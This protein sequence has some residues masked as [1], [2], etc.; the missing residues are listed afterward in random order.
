MFTQS[1][2]HRMTPTL[3]VIDPR[4]LQIRTVAYYRSVAELP[5]QAGIT[6]QVFD[7][8]TRL[9]RSW[10]A[11]LASISATPNL[12][13]TFS[14]SDKPLLADSVDTGWRVVLYGSTGVPLC[15]WDGR[16]SQRQIAYDTALRPVAITEQTQDAQPCVSERLTYAEISNEAAAHNR[17]GKL[18]RH[19][20]PAGC[21]TISDYSLA[22]EILSQS[23]CF[24]SDLL[25]PDWKL[26]LAER[27]NM[28]ESA[29]ATTRWRFDASGNVLSQ[30]DARNNETL[31]A[32]N[33]AGQLCHIQLKRPNL[34][35]KTL[36]SH[37][38]YNAEG[39]IEQETAGNDVKTTRRHAAQS[40]RVLRLTVS[41]GNHCY[42]DEHYSY[43]PVGNITHIEDAAQAVQHFRNQRTAPVST[44]QY[45]TLYQLIEATGREATPSNQGPG[46]PELHS[47]L[48]DP[49]RMGTYRQSFTYD[50][51]GNLQTLIHASNNGYARH[52][53]TSGY[54]NRSLLK[55]ETGVPDFNA[56]F[57]ANGNLQRLAPGAQ[58]LKWDIRNQLCEVQQV[59]RQGADNDHECYRYDAQG[60]RV[61]KVTLRNT[62][63]ITNN[64]EV[65]YLPGLEIH[66]SNLKE[67]RHVINIET[68]NNSVRVF[69]W[70]EPTRADIPDNQIH[71]S[72]TNPFSTSMLE[73]DDTAGVL[74][75]EGYYPFGGSAWWAA[76]NQTQ[77]DYK[78][79][80]Y[81]RMERDATGLYYYGLR[82]YAPWLQRWISPDP[83]GTLD[84][85]NLFRF[86]RNNP[87]FF[88]D[89]DGGLPVLNGPDPED[90]QLPAGMTEAQI[91]SIEMD[92]RI[93]PMSVAVILHQIPLP[94]EFKLD[95]WSGRTFKRAG[96]GTAFTAIANINTGDIYFAPLE[97][98]LRSMPPTNRTR[99]ESA[100][101]NRHGNQVRSP[102]ITHVPLGNPSHSQL[103]ERVGLNQKDVVGFALTRGL[104]GRIYN[105][106][107]MSRSSN[108]TDLEGNQSFTKGN[109]S[110]P[111]S[112]SKYKF[113]IEEVPGDPT[114]RTRMINMLP[115]EW[116]DAISSYL[117]RELG[118][119]IS[120][121]NPNPFINSPPPP[122]APAQAPRPAAPGT[123]GTQVRRL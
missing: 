66:Y 39:Q 59:S 60:Q 68:S 4:T 42:V 89:P 91:K 106:T 67:E 52:M 6:R 114:T 96:P 73:L 63:S 117:K 70:P 80:R 54:S 36:L 40:G 122:V 44:Y 100:L 21:L 13:K 43:D 37:I 104:T 84:G 120:K 105:M 18:I 77:A 72:V 3:S 27:E 62:G 8:A 58:T 112:R 103:S 95:R 94:K 93:G 87:I 56:S 32:Y 64:R 113:V 110:T 7:A 53:Q 5:A 55:P 9:M 108:N 71:Y 85:L 23:R 121:I 47:P 101:T 78:T 81:S 99:D 48:L 116:A 14:L 24:I 22:S 90:I 111:A 76:K 98:N 10:D 51:A 79:V 31:K 97:S 61:R 65:R 50:A 75:Q 86:C 123:S 49:T 115:K 17:C 69:H 92:H 19:D 38:V 109:Y 35:D 46:L 2:L 119:D 33:V 25:T 83:A 107:F 34:P 45:D 118:R 102:P 82:Y 1:H 30:C 57:D 12:R 15:Q 20:D 11:R 16:H 26:E 28:L 88:R 29:A 41:H 74:T